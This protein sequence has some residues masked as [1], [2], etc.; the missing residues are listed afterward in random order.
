[1]RAG[2][3]KAIRNQAMGLKQLAKVDRLSSDQN[4][5]NKGDHIIEVNAPGGGWAMDD[6]TDEELDPALVRRARQEEMPQPESLD[7]NEERDES[8][9]RGW[10][11]IRT[12]CSSAT[13]PRWVQRTKAGISH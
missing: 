2:L 6:L 5:N 7:R 13:Q 8:Q 9:R 10:K 1:M 4:E 11:I 12:E 3:V